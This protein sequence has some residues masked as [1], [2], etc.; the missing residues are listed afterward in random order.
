MKTTQDSN[1]SFREL[2]VVKA[3][4]KASNGIIHSVD[5]VLMPTH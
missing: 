1:I 3:D 5:N 2:S 4:L